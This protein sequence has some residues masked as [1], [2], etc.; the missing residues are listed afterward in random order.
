MK[1]KFLLIF[2]IVGFLLTFI[3]LEYSRNRED[4]DFYSEEDN[5][6]LT[7]NDDWLQFIDESGEYS[8]LY[9]ANWQLE[10]H[11]YKNELIRADVSKEGHTGLQ[12]RMLKTQQDDIRDFSEIYLDQFRSDML[13]Y[14]EGVLKETERTFKNIGRNYGCRSTII[15]EKGNGE[16]WLFLE[17]IWLR[18]DY[19]LVFQCGTK[20]EMRP[21]QESLLN[22][23]A[24]SLEFLK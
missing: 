4:L 8:L 3:F 21:D 16:D 9:P 13:N 2:V 19:A 11:S 10:D 18:D 7:D 15:M 5:I 6:Y 24:A 12:I 20:L 23:I 22:Q 17:F 1:R 14:W